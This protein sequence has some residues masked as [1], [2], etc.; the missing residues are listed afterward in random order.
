M[1]IFGEYKVANSLY[2]MANNPPN[3]HNFS[4]LDRQEGVTLYNNFL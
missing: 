2:N 3:I 4:S 1:N